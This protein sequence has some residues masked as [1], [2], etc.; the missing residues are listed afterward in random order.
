MTWAAKKLHHRDHREH[1]GEN[2]E[3]PLFAVTSVIF[4]GKILLPLLIVLLAFAVRVHNLDSQSLWNDEGNSLRL[5]ERSIPDLIDAAG[6][7]IHPPGY[8]LALKGWIAVAGTSEI[9]LR[10]LSVFEGVLAVGFRDSGVARVRRGAI[11]T[12]RLDGGECI[13]EA[14]ECFNRSEKTPT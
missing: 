10:V 11:G 14:V 13:S 3:N 6:R 2:R 12:W 9:S 8:Y 1:R 4:V 5:A 7:D